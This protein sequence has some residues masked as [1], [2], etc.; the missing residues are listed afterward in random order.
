MTPE[1]ERPPHFPLAIPPGEYRLDAAVDDALRVT[2]GAAARVDDTAHPALAFVL[3]LGGAGEE[4]ATTLRRSGYSIELAPLLA[5]CEI[6][7]SE[8]LT[9]G[10][11]Y[12]VEG[13]VAGVTRK[14]SRR[15]GTADHLRLSY[16]FAADGRPVGT[17]SLTMV[18]G[19]HIDE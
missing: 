5:G 6:R 11:L 8:R 16:S 2:S 4:I 18:I 14:P 1:G 9:V 7:F 10:T 13:E 19:A 17:L 15:F 3:A 12:R